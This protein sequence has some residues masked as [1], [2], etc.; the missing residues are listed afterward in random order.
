M[1]GPEGD[2]RF[3]PDFIGEDHPTKKMV[4]CHPDNCTDRLAG[5]KKFPALEAF[6]SQH[7]L[8]ASHDVG[9]SIDRGGHPPSKDRLEVFRLHGRSS[10]CRGNPTNGPREGVLGESGQRMGYCLKELFFPLKEFDLS[11]REISRSE[12]SCLIESNDTHV[13]KRFNGGTSPVEDPAPRAAR[14]GRED[15]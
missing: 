8:P 7:Q 13:G 15:R 10:P 1:Q 3:W 2:C 4:A 14:D 12:C 6:E 9:L 11:Q 5:R